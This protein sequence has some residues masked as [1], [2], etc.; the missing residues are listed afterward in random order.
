MCLCDQLRKLV[1]KERPVGRVSL[2]PCEILSYFIN[3]SLGNHKSASL[4]GTNKNPLETTDIYNILG[5]R[6]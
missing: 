6:I 1:A 4:K 5:K 3:T 2:E